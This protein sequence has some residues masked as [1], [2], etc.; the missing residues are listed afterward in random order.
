MGGTKIAGRVNPQNFGIFFGIFEFFKIRRPIAGTK[1]LI[2]FS[3]FLS[4]IARPECFQERCM[5]CI[6]S[7]GTSGAGPPIWPKILRIFV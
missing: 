2:F 3:K 5:E 1:E 6:F 7:D 4:S